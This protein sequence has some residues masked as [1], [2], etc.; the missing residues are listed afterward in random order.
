MTDQ[1]HD[2]PLHHHL[3]RGIYSS[4]GDR[5]RSQEQ[6]STFKI[7]SKKATS[8]TV[9][10]NIRAGLPATLERSDIVRIVNIAWQHYFARFETHTKAITVRGWGPL[11][12]ILMDHPELQEIKDRVKLINEIYEKQVRDGVDI[13]DLATLNT[14]VSSMGLCMDTFLDHKIQE[15]A[16]G[17]M[18][19]AEKKEKRRQPGQIKKERGARFSAG[20]MA[21]TYRYVIGPQ[22]FAWARRKSLEKERKKEARQRSGRLDIIRLKTK[23]G[24]VIA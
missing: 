20:L 6:N 23:V 18:T 13:T 15:Q 9:T 5:R 22:C 19:L 8:D 21:I 4:Y 11:N 24:M 7:E 16:L 14:E 1:K 2:E 10:G 12:Y 3:L 17:E